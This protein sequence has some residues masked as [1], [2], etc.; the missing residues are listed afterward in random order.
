VLSIDPRQIEAFLNIALIVAHAHPRANTEF[1]WLG[2][3]FEDEQFDRIPSRWRR[4]V[5]RKLLYLGLKRRSKPSTL[6]RYADAWFRMVGDRVLV[7]PKIPRL[8]I[9]N[10]YVIRIISDGNQFP[11]TSPVRSNYSWMVC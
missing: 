7:I 10:S 5:Y 3:L 9:G 11:P 6:H 4:Y 2:L 1:D 8:F